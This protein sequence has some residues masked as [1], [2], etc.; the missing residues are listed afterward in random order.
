[1]SW[2][3]F[4][5]GMVVGSTIGITAMCIVFYGR[6]SEMPGSVAEN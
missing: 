2:V 3:M 1:M 6:E 4:F 5:L